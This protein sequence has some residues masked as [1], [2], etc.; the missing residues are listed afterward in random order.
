MNHPSLKVTKRNTFRW[1]KGNINIVHPY[2]GQKKVI[3][4]EFEGETIN[5][6][7]HGLCFLTYSG[8]KEK[9][10]NFR[11][12]ATMKHGVLHGGQ[13]LFSSGCG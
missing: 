5:G 1:V 6:T 11:G 3:S 4:V 13:A 8:D 7:P 9:G 2:S 10:N 12:T